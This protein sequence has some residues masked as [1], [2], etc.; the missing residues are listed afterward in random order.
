MKKRS[1]LILSVFLSLAHVL[2]AQSIEA[3]LQ[4]DIA[5]K[6]SNPTSPAE[7]S[8]GMFG[9][10][11]V[12]NFVGV[13]AIQVPVYEIK[14]KGLTVPIVL[15][16]NNSGIKVNDEASWVGLGWRLEAGGVITR[17]KRGLPD[18]LWRAQ[19]PTYKEFG[20]LLDHGQA[21]NDFTDVGKSQDEIRNQFSVYD[22]L[23]IKDGPNHWSSPRMAGQEGRKSDTQ[24][25]LFQFTFAGKSGK[26]VFGTDQKPKLFSYEPFIFDYTLNQD[27][28][29]GWVD[30]YGS[31]Y[32]SKGIT[33]F[34]VTDESGN[35]YTFSEL[36]VS[37]YVTRGHRV[38][39]NCD[40]GPDGENFYQYFPFTTAWYLTSIE[41][42][43]GE[44]VS[45]NYQNEA[46]ETYQVEETVKNPTSFSDG[47]LYRSGFSTTQS[48][49]INK[50][51]S[52][53]ETPYETITFVAGVGRV[54]LP[55][56]KTLSDIQIISKFN[57]KLIKQ[58]HFSY[59]YFQSPVNS[60]SDGALKV[61]YYANSYYRL[62]LRSV[63]TTV[64]GDLHIGKYDFFYDEQSTL[65]AKYSRQQDFWGYYNANNA[66]HLFPKLYISP[67]LTGPDRF[68]VFQLRDLT[69]PQ[70]FVL[71]G[72]DRNCNPSTVSSGTL[73][74]I[75][76]P[77]GGYTIY[78]YEP[79]DFLYRGRKFSGGGL[80]VKKI[81]DYDGLSHNKDITKV[82]KY[83]QSSDTT[84][85]SGVLFNLPIFAYK[86]NDCSSDGLSSSKIPI[87]Y[88]NN[89]LLNFKSNTIRM[90][91][92]MSIMGLGDEITV[93]YSDVRETIT[94]SGYT[95]L[96]YATP[97]RY[98]DQNDLSGAGCNISEVSFC[99]GIY[100]TPM[101]KTGRSFTFSI[102]EPPIG[103]DFTNQDLSPNS[104][105]FIQNSNY[106][107][108]RGLLMSKEVYDVNN[109]LKRKTDYS[110]N[111]FSPETGIYNVTGFLYTHG[112][113]FNIGIYAGA[114]A[115]PVVAQ[116]LV[117]YNKYKIITNVNKLPA[118]VTQTD[119]LA[120]GKVISSS[121]LTYSKRKFLKS[122]DIMDSQGMINRTTYRY[123]FDYGVITNSVLTEFNAISS[124]V[125]KN[126]IS[127]PL[128]TVQ[129]IIKNGSGKI[130]GAKTT[131]MNF[132]GNNVLPSKEIYLNL[133]A[134]I[135]ENQY[136]NANV[137]FEEGWE[138]P[139]I[140]PFMSGKVYFSKYDDM[141]NVLEFSDERGVPNAVTWGYNRL[142]PTSS[143]HNAKWSDAY[144]E[145][146]EEFMGSGLSILNDCRT[147]H[148]SKANGFSKT[149]T[150]ITNKKYVLTYW[151]KTSNKWE[152]VSIK[153][154]DI[155]N[156]SYTIS[157]NGTYQVDDICFYPQEAQMTTS[158]YEPLVG[159]TSVTNPN[160]ITV[161]YEY[162]DFNRLKCVKDESGNI[163]KLMD[164][165]LRN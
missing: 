132:Y 59:D 41:T 32:L 36:E 91:N 164:Y 92:P 37:E 139:V 68:S 18:D 64:P 144:H 12:D 76:Y 126:I 94:N 153:N 67:A 124:L 107:W 109:V 148:F 43:V 10:N 96:K 125:K 40:I 75:V 118:T 42:A 136:T 19:P 44:I 82:Y 80:R 130:T 156:N 159:L 8:L 77:T 163:V 6:A 145:N 60:V 70:Y 123:P 34:Y 49:V 17:S 84:K 120:G 62:K 111:L 57:N 133:Q 72:A 45:F 157:I 79:H 152:Y 112:F 78:E 110:Y 90:T 2:S 39:T 89:S 149:L 50:R 87:D 48:K 103:P 71:D 11:S 5:R 155:S 20:F 150:G 21:A 95:W 93:G 99:D 7:A 154:I 117:Y 83:L 102:S 116:S 114:N 74:R 23:L 25:D 58:T 30:N 56:S 141:G 122:K 119:Y 86:E 63:Q 108:N 55:S 151:K 14:L 134:P 26:F 147:G 143:T 160:G 69:D 105:P 97:L 22:G 29:P 4:Q 85:T 121:T 158:T 146:F 28:N 31:P 100:S 106:D 165:N 52:S 127:V 1:L 142:Y 137:T 73:N 35:K 16:Y 131:I 27:G 15:K 24:P 101:I 115:G 3:E 81:T 9:G 51:L 53:I 46:L 162:D 104:Y 161:Y 128:E 98:G 13:P 135:S 88:A 61:T 66:S 138:T 54:D 33:S 38:R 65:P 140:D 47:N 129:T 113:N